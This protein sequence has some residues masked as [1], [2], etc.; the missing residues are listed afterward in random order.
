MKMGR[1]A[2]GVYALLLA[3]S[4]QQRFVYRANTYIYVLSTLLGLFVMISIWS[5]LYQSRDTVQG[6][7]FEEMVSFVMINTVAG[8]M[9]R[10]HIAGKIGEKVVDGSIALDLIKPV[11]FK[12]YLIADQLGENMYRLVFSVLP[13]CL[14]AVLVWGFLPPVGPL[15][16]LLFLFSLLSGAVLMY[17]LHYVFGLTTF[18]FKTSFYVDWFMRACFQLFAGSFVPLWFYPQPLVSISL[19]LPFHLVTFQPVN[20]YLGRRS[21]L[22]SLQ[23]IGWQWAW[24]AALLL[25]EWWLWR[26]IQREITV[27]GG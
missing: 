21:L 18:W 17:Q 5:A 10:T 27:N 1:L 15:Q 20:I 24:I 23:A 9:L 8:A 26:R 11:H 7:R 6:I 12:A 19:L 3:K 22:E 25:L 16:L 4:F 13:A 2:V 14:V